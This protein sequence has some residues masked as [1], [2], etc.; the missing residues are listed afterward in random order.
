MKVIQINSTLPARKPQFKEKNIKQQQF[1][2]FMKELNVWTAKEL[3]NVKHN[4]NKSTL[5]IE[6]AVD[7]IFYIRDIK[8]K[9]FKEKLYGIEKKQNWLSK[10][11]SKRS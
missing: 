5:D 2:S 8:I 3:A 7:Y 4:K 9:K 10:L 1:D 11:F 6:I